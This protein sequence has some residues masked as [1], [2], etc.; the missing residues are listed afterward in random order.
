MMK[1]LIWDEDSTF[2]N[3]YTSSAGVL[4]YM[5]QILKDIKGKMNNKTITRG[6]FNIPLTSIDGSA[7]TQ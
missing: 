4:R 3:I 7:M 6:D 1:G 5:K 2:H